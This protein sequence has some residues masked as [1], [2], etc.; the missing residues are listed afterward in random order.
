VLIGGLILLFLALVLRGATRNR[1][2]RGRLLGAAVAFALYVAVRAM[3]AYAPISDEFRQQLLFIGPLIMM[4]G[5]ISGTVAV[6]IN[7]WSVDRLPDRFPNIVQDALVIALFALAATVVLQEKILAT[8]A[9][10]AVV[11]G[12]ALQDTLGNLFAG[13]A[14]Q[15]EKPFRVGH[16]VNIAGKDGIVSE[17]TWRATKIRTKTGNLVVVPNST[18]S[19]DTITNYSE[20]TS[21][22][23]LEVEVGATYDAP[24]NVV[25]SV[26]LEALKTEPLVTHERAPE[27]LLVDF[28]ASSI[29][30]RTR[31]W[32]DDFAADER[33]KDRVRSIIYYAFKRNGISIPYPI[34]VEMHYEGNAAPEAERG[35][36]AAALDAVE[37]FSALEDAERAELLRMAHARLYAAGETIV[38][39]GESGSSM[40]VIVSGEATVTLAPDG[41][42]VF[43]F[44]GRGFF[45][46]MSLLTGEPR[47]A[48]VTAVTDCDLLEITVDAFRRFVLANPQVVEQVGMATARRAAEI[49]K[50]RAAGAAPPAAAA[51]P[52]S[53]VAR[54][55]RFLGVGVLIAFAVMAPAVARASDAPAGSSM[56]ITNDGR[57]TV[58][59]LETT[60]PITLDG[61][62]DEAVWAAAEPASGFVQAEPHEGQPASEA[63]EVRIAYDRDA[64]YIAVRCADASGAGAIVNDIRKDFVAGE[65]DSF[66]IILD[67]FADR[68]N[69]FVFVVNAVGGKSDTQIANE[70]RDVNTSWDAVWSV[71][72]HADTSGWTAEI[73]IPFKTLRFESGADRIWGV[74]FSRR[75]RRRNEVDFWSPVPRV[76]NLYRASL[77]GT[78]TGL[79]NANPGRNL[80]IK[81]WISGDTTRALSGSDFSNKAH[82]GLDV[83]Y[84]VTP[85]LTLDVTVRPDFA[86]AEADEQQVNLTQFSLF[87]PEKR[88]FFLENSGMFYFGDIPRESR[89][90]SA[91]FA[92]PEEEILLFF[93]RRIGLTSAGDPL[94]ISAGGRL[95]GRAAGTGIGLMTIQTESADGRDGDNYTVLRGR[96]DVLRN[97]DVGGIFLSRQSAGSGGRNEVAG[98]DAN[99]RFVKALS[100]NGFLARSFTP[101]VD[102]GQVAGKGSI[103]WNANTL[104]TQYSLLSIGDNFR[105]DIGFIKRTGIRKHFADFGVRKRPD[106]LRRFGIR[107]LHPHTR[108]NIYTDQS[109]DKV[110]H[111]NHVAMAAFF[112]RGGFVEVQWNPRFERILTPFKVRPDQAFAAGTYGWNEYAV[113]LE[114][115]HSRKVSGS[116]L[117][118]SGGFWSGTQRSA[119]I[120]VVYRPSY[121]LTFD[122]ALQRNDITLPAPMRDFTTN[123]VTSRIGYAF[124][125]RTFLDTLLQYNTDL[126][127]FSANV[128]LDLIHRPLSDL[129]VVYNQQQLTDSPVPVNA[130]RGLILKYTHMLAF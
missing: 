55:R 101:G 86:Q 19:K 100:I 119:K 59:A 31:V 64:M 60:T 97:G 35:P 33:V 94:P 54:I 114:T 75:I 124:N 74:N 8:T 29:T 37:I 62:L 68:R 129:F 14:I 73:R 48:T 106:A 23:R 39:Q 25:K 85:S 49:A 70:G 79:P 12:F 11:V 108:A 41:H 2:V 69:G 71:A 122:T 81:P 1:H 61:A 43:R 28:A 58:T 130:G 20:P 45:G 16:W 42:E 22:T 66:E 83:K 107:E 76:Y 47:T 72:T 56:Q 121:H 117:I 123:L 78:M 113:E 93:S 110:S 95:T 44:N 89:L 32:T 112:E 99:F 127:Q 7:P 51:T 65:Q 3:L 24:P 36:A 15:I 9:V 46:E 40:F 96:R 126:K 21:L 30:Y 125:T 116:A 10:G 115:D 26:I 92:P 84:G 103:T 98:V 120:G 63:T 80:R 18:L 27:V 13:L 118:T 102:S 90:G 57:R 91:R 53:L 34:Q 128:R 4:F 82:A 67:T 87:Y 109:N 111:T 50:V 52:E 6:A 105:D 104:H 5:L 38:R 17:I 88:E 77:A